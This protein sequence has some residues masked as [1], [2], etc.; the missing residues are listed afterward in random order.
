MTRA[1]PV[2]MRRFHVC[3]HDATPA[4]A[5]ETRVMLRDLA[6]VLGRC[7]S[8]GVV[9]DWH[10]KWPLPA[11]PDFCRL[12][13]E[14][15][16]EL[17]L[18]GYRHRRQRGFGPISILTDRSD[19]M[20]GLDREETRR[21]VA[22]AQDV[23]TEAFGAAA[24]GFVA[25]AWQPGHVRAGQGDALQLE[26]VLGFFSLESRAGRTIPLATWAWDGGRWRWPGHIGPRIGRVV[27]ALRGAVPVL[28]IHP[29]DL[30]RGFWLQIVGLVEQ[31][32]WRGYEPATLA[33]L[34]EANDDDVAP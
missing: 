23:F 22:G 29:R 13:R 27:H 6:S 25:P 12:V 4:Y 15:A 5:R 19:E 16:E 3:I 7:L 18:H 32:L 10:G 34:L 11:Y 30:D 26:Y 33:G 17:L 2:R 31:L 28:A 24:R 9:P 21:T 8:C 1:R 14:G 20:N